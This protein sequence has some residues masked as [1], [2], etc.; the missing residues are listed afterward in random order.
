[1]I[2]R[3][4]LFIIFLSIYINA[5]NLKFAEPEMVLIKNG[6]FIMGN[7]D[8]TK[9]EHYTVNVNLEYDFYIGKY[10]ISFDEYDLFC[11]ETNRKKV[12]DEG[13]G[14]GKRPVINISWNDAQSYVKWLSEKTG[15][16]YR[17]PSESEWEYAARGGTQ[18][19][20]SF[21]NSTKNICDY[22]NLADK[23][24]YFKWKINYCSDNYANTSP[25]GSFKA[26]NFGLYDM[27]GNVWEWVEDKFNY[28]D[29]GPNN[30]DSAINAID[31]YRVIRGGSFVLSKNIRVTSRGMEKASRKGFSIGFRIVK[32]NIDNTI[33]IKLLNDGVKVD[34]KV[35]MKQSLVNGTFK[36]ITLINSNI[37]GS[38][39][40]NISFKKSNFDKS[41]FNSIHFENVSIKDSILD[42]TVFHY[43]TMI[44][45]DLENSSFIKAKFWHANLQGANFKNTNLDKSNF[46]GANLKNADL[47]NTSLRRANFNYTVL[48]GA[49]L[50][51][52]KLKQTLFEGANLTGA[53]WINGKICKKGSVGKCIQ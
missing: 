12:S 49:N 47:R 17:L 44:N 18:T 48:Y 23:S 8:G 21:G 50:T 7:K 33:L 11:I 26:N 36:N 52:G 30:G 14:R 39:F 24:S 43:S 22:I 5:N 25:I 29:R 9:W 51:G 31:N 28:Y 37:H 45:G 4:F 10:E 2:I 40:K 20:Y 46:Y 6:S 35:Y 41:N 13:W 3:K 42:S 15:K 32:T 27:Q 1:M 16:Y 19:T 38:K 34:G 53:I